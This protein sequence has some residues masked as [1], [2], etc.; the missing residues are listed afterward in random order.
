MKLTIVTDFDWNDRIHGN[1]AESFWI[2]VED[3]NSN[4]IYHYEYFTLL[5]KQVALSN[6]PERCFMFIIISCLENT[7]NFLSYIRIIFP[8]KC[9]LLY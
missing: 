1:I 8:V 4:V 9:E 7:S 2:W 3:P 6:W 5:K